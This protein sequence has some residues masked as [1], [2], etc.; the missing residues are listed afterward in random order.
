MIYKVYRD[1]FKKEVKKTG[2]NLF[3]I[4]EKPKTGSIDDRLRVE[5][6]TSKFLIAELTDGN[7]GAYWEAGFAEGLGKPVIYT[8]ERSYFN[9]E[10]THF[11]TN[12]LYTVL[13]EPNEL[14][15]AAERLKITIRASLPEDAKLEDD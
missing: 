5:I 12:H 10:R 6:R 14:D 15:K 13:W 11:D 4:D 1:Y 9:N 2:F 3:R 8:C 7:P